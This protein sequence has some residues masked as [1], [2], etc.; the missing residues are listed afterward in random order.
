MATA[1]NIVA[2]RP[3]DGRLDRIDANLK[4]IHTLLKMILLASGGSMPVTSVPTNFVGDLI[5]TTDKY[6]ELYSNNYNRLVAVKVVA[7]FAI[8]GSTL[9]LSLQSSDNGRIATL[10]SLGLVT[11]DTIWLQPRQTLYVN[12]ADTAFTL[13]GT[14]IRVLMFDPLSFTVS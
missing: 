13:A 8:P 9:K 7:D 2:M 10:S 1:P 5:G 14:T 3:Q 12:S 6:L 4:E 11:S